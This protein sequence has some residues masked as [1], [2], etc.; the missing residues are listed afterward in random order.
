M[1]SRVEEAVGHGRVPHEAHPPLLGPGLEGEHQIA[2][3]LIIDVG[4]THGPAGTNDHVHGEVRHAHLGQKIN[5]VWQDAPVLLVD[6]GVGVSVNVGRPQVAHSLHR[7]LE[8]SWVGHHL[9]VDGSLPRLQADL[10]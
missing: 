1:L 9:V 8:G 5:E 3:G 2:N 6:G 4:H 10:S 7:A